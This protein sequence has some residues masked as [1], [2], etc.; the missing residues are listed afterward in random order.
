[1]T[2]FRLSRITAPASGALVTL[3]NAD[4]NNES[5]AVFRPLTWN[6][7]DRSHVSVGARY[8]DG[9]ITQDQSIGG[10]EVVGVVAAQILHYT[11]TRRFGVSL[12]IER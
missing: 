3:M 11:Y 7:I 1:M 6:V 2:C 4:T 8:N 5:M 9:K 12:Q 10:Q